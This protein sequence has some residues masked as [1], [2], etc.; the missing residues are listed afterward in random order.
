MELNHK[1]L[2]D[3]KPLLV[4]HGLFGLL[5]NWSG[6]AKAFAKNRRVYLLDLRNHGRSPHD[7]V[8]DYEAMSGDLHEFIEKHGIENPDII[9]HSMGGKVAMYLAGRYQPELL[10]RLVV[11]D[12]AP[13]YYPV[14]HRTIIDALAGVDL[15]AL[16]SRQEADDQLARNIPELAVRQFLLK[17][18]YR[19][20]EGG[21]A[22]RFNLAA[23]DQDIENVGEALPAHFRYERPTLFIRGERSNYI[24]DDDWPLVLEHFPNA[25]LETVTD[26]GHWV[27]AEK[28]AELL[29][30]VNAFLA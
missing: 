14:H 9:G 19:T 25:R 17:S 23:I 2:G 11:V 22:W 8:F 13:R 27:H 6:L 15:A 30:L 26:A 4:L 5:D 3:G 28:P 21:F 7:P 20:D 24:R 29:Q 16:Q 1:V 10:D 12:I 18:L